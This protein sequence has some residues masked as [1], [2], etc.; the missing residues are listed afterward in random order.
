MKNYIVYNTTTGEIVNNVS[1]QSSDNFSPYPTDFS[2]L[3]VAETIDNSKYYINPK[4]QEFIAFSDRPD[5]YHTWN[6]T[7]K[8]WQDLRSDQQKYSQAVT[9][10]QRQ[11][12][13][14][15]TDSDWVVTKAIDQGTQVPEAWQTYRQQLRDITQQSGYPFTVTWPTPVQ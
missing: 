14:L 6:W 4:S 11:R 1:T 7:T 13:K 3:E 8:I 10:I 2:Y 15:L 12:S 5:Q 9:Q